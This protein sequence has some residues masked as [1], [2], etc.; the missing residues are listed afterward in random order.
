MMR[1]LPVVEGHGDLAA[2]PLLVRRVLHELHNRFDVEL[3]PAQRRGEWPKVKREFDRYFQAATLERAAILWVL[4]FDCD[5]C[6]DVDSERAWALERAARLDPKTPIELV[7]LVKEFE[8]LFLWDDSALRSAFGEL[9]VDVSVPA[10][11]EQVRDAKGCVSLML[12]KGRAYKP[13]TDQ[14]R[15][16]SRLDLAILSECSPSFTRFLRAVESLCQPQGALH[17]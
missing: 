10:N 9:A 13:T 1:L 11:P 4:D 16:V 6:I 2:V 17:S 5:D 8:S 3:L 12:P 14:A 15:I 7:F